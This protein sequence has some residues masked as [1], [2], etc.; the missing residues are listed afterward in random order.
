MPTILGV[1]PGDEDV[2]VLETLRS[3]DKLLEGC[4]RLDEVVWSQRHAKLVAQVGDALGFRL[5]AA[6]GQQDE[7]NVVRIK[8]TQRFGCAGDGFSDVEQ[9]AVDAGSVS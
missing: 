7:G 2:L 1:C 5:A 3:L 9:Y 8:V 4:V 6:I